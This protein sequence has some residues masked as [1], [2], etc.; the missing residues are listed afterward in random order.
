MTETL[1]PDITLRVKFDKQLFGRDT[2]Q[3][4]RVYWG[5][6]M[7]PEGDMFCPFHMSLGYVVRNYVPN[8]DTV[9]FI[10]HAVE[11][12]VL[13][14]ADNMTVR[15]IVNQFDQNGECQWIG[16]QL[17]PDSDWR[18]ETTDGTNSQ[19][20]RIVHTIQTMFFDHLCQQGILNRY[21]V[22]FVGLHA[23]LELRQ[24]RPASL[25]YLRQRENWPEVRA[26]LFAE[27]GGKCKKFTRGTKV[28]HY[29]VRFLEDLSAISVDGEK[30]IY[31]V[32]SYNISPE[33]PDTTEDKFA[34]CTSQEYPMGKMLESF[35]SNCACKK[36]RGTDEV[37]KQTEV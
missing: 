4:S 29:P 2:L 32:K 11:E 33:T 7:D 22:H 18:L 12:Q 26:W 28:W 35:L 19:L 30:T 15:L 34:F 10:L 27:T 6:G 9:R 1:G 16:C 24:Q 23:S 20:L 36:R 13:A 14:S 3:Y 5:L 17:H 8:W 37:M 25:C 31:Y 21:S